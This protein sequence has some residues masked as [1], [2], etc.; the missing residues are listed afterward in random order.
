[1]KHHLK[2]DIMKH[3][4]TD[5]NAPPQSRGNPQCMNAT[6]HECLPDFVIQAGVNAE[7]LQH[8]DCSRFARGKPVEA[9]NIP[10]PGVLFRPTGR[11][12]PVLTSSSGPP[13][14]SQMIFGVPAWLEQEKPL[15]TSPKERGEERSRGKPSVAS[16]K[17]PAARG[18]PLVVG[19]RK[20]VARGK[21]PEEDGNRG[22][23]ARGM[24]PIARGKPLTARGKPPMTRG[25]PPAA[26]DK[27]DVARDRGHPPEVEYDVFHRAKLPEKGEVWKKVGRRKTVV[28]GRVPLGLGCAKAKLPE[29][30]EVWNGSKGI[31][32]VNHSHQLN[33]KTR[34]RP[35]PSPAPRIRDW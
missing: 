13:G 32:Q 30:G 22:P 7:R 25:M 2:M 10:A 17:P 29:M 4:L 21:P 33:R 18:K 19:S 28:C 31:E 16:G 15:P 1:M 6:M 34:R 3:K 24:P 26:R 5:S 14:S 9:A 27:P 20:P 12:G 35:Q 11:D 23:Y 8:R